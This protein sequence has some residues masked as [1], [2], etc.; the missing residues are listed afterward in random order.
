MT[1]NEYLSAIRSIIIQVSNRNCNLTTNGYIFNNQYLLDLQFLYIIETCYRN[2]ELFDETELSNLNEMLYE[3]NLKIMGTTTYI[4]GGTTLTLDTGSTI[5][6]IP[7]DYKTT[8]YKVLNLFASYGESASR[9][10]VTSKQESN[11]IS[12]ELYNIINAAISARMLEQT[13]IATN[14]YNYVVAKLSILSL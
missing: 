11:K 4:I 3:L 12:I 5:M 14:L 2:M 10:F 1:Q 9:E 8:Y 6:V 7:D 13:T